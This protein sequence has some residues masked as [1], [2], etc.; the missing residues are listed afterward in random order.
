LLL[1]LGM[2]FCRGADLLTSSIDQAAE[3]GD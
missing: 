3:A 2:G 1:V